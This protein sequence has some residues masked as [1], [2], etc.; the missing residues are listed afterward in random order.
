MS[1]EF[2]TLQRQRTWSL[3]PYSPTMNV[4]RCCWVYKLKHRPNGSIARYKARLVAKG[5][6]PTHGVDYNETFS[7]IVKQPT[8][9]VVSALTVHFDWPLH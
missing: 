6:H 9:Q 7:P 4:V 5:F 3:V 8:I 2:S 1:T